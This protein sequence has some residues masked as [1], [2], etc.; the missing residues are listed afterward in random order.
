MSFYRSIIRLTALALLLP[1]TSPLAQPLP[2]FEGVYVRL[3]DDSEP[4]RVCRSH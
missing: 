1:T 3:A 4:R 2:E